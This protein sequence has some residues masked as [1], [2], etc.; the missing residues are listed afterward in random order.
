MANV[1]GFNAASGSGE[2]FSPGTGTAV[3]LSNYVTLTTTQS[4]SGQKLFSNIN[5]TFY[6]TF[7]G[8]LEGT[9]V[10]TTIV[11]S[12][13]VVPEVGGAAGYISAAGDI[14]SATQLGAP[15][16][17]IT[18]DAQIDG[19]LTVTDLS[20]D[21]GIIDDL[22]CQNL[23]VSICAGINTLVPSQAL[24][25]TGNVKI[26]AGGNGVIF[27]DGSK[28]TSANFIPAELGNPTG[29]ISMFAGSI[30]PTGY[31]LCNGALYDPA[32]PLYAALFNIIGYAY[33]L[34]P[35]FDHF[36]VPDLRGIFASM[37]GVNATAPYHWTGVVIEGPSS[38]GSYQKQSTIFIDHKHDTAYPN[39]TNDATYPGGRSFYQSGSFAINKESSFATDIDLPDSLFTQVNDYVRPC[40]VGVNY[41]IKL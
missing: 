37:P 27:P 28:L 29:S 1:Y 34:I 26:N 36:Q 35:Y 20:V 38:I 16:L 18:E 19:E 21:T 4:I 31:V 11:G 6:G 24:D 9:S 3:D 23:Q 25:V 17:Y 13:T 8:E 10:A 14:T 40:T 7:I 33:T 5:N 30:A 32:D 39:Q 12:L 15:Q 22:L 2:S 41:I